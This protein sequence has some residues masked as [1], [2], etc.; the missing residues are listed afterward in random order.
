MTTM[1]DKLVA[2]ALEYEERARYLRLAAAEMN[3]HALNGKRE[4]AVGTLDAAI[5]L[6]KAQRSTN[7]HHEP[8]PRGVATTKDREATIRALLADG[9]QTTNDIRAQLTAAG[10]E[11]ST[12]W[13]L[14][15]LNGM[16]GVR[17]QG[18]G[19]QS[20]WALGKVKAA[21]PKRMMTRAVI[22]QGRERTAKILAKYDEANPKDP[23]E[24]AKALG[25]TVP[26]S[27]LAPLVHQGYL[28]KRKGG[29]IRTRKPYVVAVD[30]AAP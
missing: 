24:V 15:L 14:K 17:Q 5:A 27:G 22:R 13:I 7:G 9:P 19:N 2:R 1:L 12:S 28:K 10:Q 29:Y 25:L 26:Q 30:T 8:G 11:C 23:A 18:S 6:R 4:A 3:G 21:K 20:R 16:K